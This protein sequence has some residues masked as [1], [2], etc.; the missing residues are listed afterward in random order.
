MDSFK[1]KAFDQKIL[2]LKNIG[3][4]K[5]LKKPISQIISDKVKEFPQTNEMH[6]SRNY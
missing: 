3:R 1:R 5:K 6:C 2:D 4:E